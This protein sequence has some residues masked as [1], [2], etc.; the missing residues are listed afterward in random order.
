MDAQTGT[1][2]TPLYS[3]EPPVA[4]AAAVAAENPSAASVGA[5]TAGAPP[6]VGLARSLFLPPRMT[7]PTGG[8]APAPSHAAAAAPSKLPNA[9]GSKKG[10]TS[11]KKKAADGSGSSKAKKKLAG[12]RTGAAS[13]EAPASSLVEPAA[14]A[15]HVFNEMPPSLNDDAYMSTMG[16]G[17]NNSHW[18]QTN[19]IHLDDHEFEVDEEGE[20]IVE[21]PKGRAGNYTTND[22]KLLC[23]TWLQVSRDPSIGGDQSRDAYWGRMKEYFDAENVSGIDGFERSLRSRWSTI[24]SDCQKW[25]AAQKAVDKLNP[26]GTNK[27]DRYNIAQNLFKEETRTTKKGKIKKGKIFTLPHCYEVLKDDEKWKKREDLDDLHLSNKRKRTIELN[28]D[29]EVEDASSDDGKRSPT[30]NSV[31]Y[32]KPKR[33]DGCKKDK[34]ENKKRK[35]DD[36]LTNAM[37][38]IVKARKEANEV[39]K[40]ARNQDAAAEE[41]R[42]AAEERRVAAEERKVALEERKVGMEE[43]AK[44]LEWEKHLFFLDTSLFNDAQKEYVNLAREEVLIQKRAMIRGMG[45]GGLG[46]MGGGG[47]GGMGGGGLGAMGGGGLGGMGGGGLGAMGGM[48]GFGAMGCIGAPPAAMGGM[49]GFGAPS[50]AMAA[51]GGMSFAS[52]MGGMGAPPAAMGGMGA[53]PAMGGRSFDVPPHTHSHEDAVEDLAN[54]VGASRDAVRDEVREKDSSTEAEESSSENEDEDEEDDD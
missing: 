35:G 43:R 41:R 54:T 40:M 13:I 27:D 49:G 36:E 51:M 53:P 20:G 24:N 30:P 12:R 16:L 19:D 25:A 48:G 44:L 1:P 17:S 52:L 28:D 50:D 31:S 11:A 14:D 2:L 37:E 3:R 10:K 33:P 39:R 8:V 34:T 26:S 32:S 29:E 5:A 7:T 15:H 46:A 38:A 45:G 18:S 47:L 22:D 21:A 4:A 6:T 42:L 9:V 23:N